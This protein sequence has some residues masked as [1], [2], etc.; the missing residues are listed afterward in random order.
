MLLIGCESSDLFRCDEIGMLLNTEEENRLFSLS[1]RRHNCTPPCDFPLVSHLYML[2]MLF[3]CF[4]F[5]LL[6]TIW[7]LD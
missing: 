5:V 4:A 6:Y 3:N 7:V 2:F 1:V